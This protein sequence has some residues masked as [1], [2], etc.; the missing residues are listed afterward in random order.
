[1]VNQR[2]LSHQN[3]VNLLIS[4]QFNVFLETL[5]G[6]GNQAIDTPKKPKAGVR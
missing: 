4:H 1:M 2:N 5:I 6:A 3:L